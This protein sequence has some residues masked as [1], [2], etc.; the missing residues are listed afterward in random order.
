MCRG[1]YLTS[2]VRVEIELRSGYFFWAQNR[3]A[4]EVIDLQALFNDYW[5]SN[6]HEFTVLSQS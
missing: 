6:E 1:I 3:R 5:S 4:S 2:E